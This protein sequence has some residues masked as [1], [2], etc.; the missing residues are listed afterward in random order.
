MDPF[1]GSAFEHLTSD[2][3]FRCTVVG[4]RCLLACLRTNTP[5]PE[6]PFPLYTAAMRGLNVS[7][8]GLD[9][10]EKKDLKLLVERMSGLYSKNFHDGVTHLVAG[11]VTSE[12]YSVAVSKEIPVM[13][14]G[15]LR[16]VWRSSGATTAVTA[17]EPRFSSF[18]CPALLGVTVS[19]SKMGKED[20]DILRKAVS[21]HGGQYSPSLE[22]DQTTVLVTPSASG[23]KYIA[24]KK[25]NI[26]CVTSNWVFE[27]IEA[28]HM[29]PFQGFRLDSQKTNAS[30]PTKQDMTVAGLAEVS[31]CSTILNPD[32]TMAARWANKSTPL[33]AWL[34]PLPQVRRGHYKLDRAR[35]GPGD[36]C[37]WAGYGRLAEGAGAGQGQEGRQLP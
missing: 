13:T 31:L 21:N 8:T 7:F 6:M 30:T 5:V 14:A 28:G 36:G 35:V 10:A 33:L 34:T 25:W 12:K 23:D 29:L 20:K 32:E 4:P 37:A 1:S 2:S 9:P 22:K 27:S 17:T 16:E 11:N 3:K 24:A 15:W 18:R 26:P 19:V